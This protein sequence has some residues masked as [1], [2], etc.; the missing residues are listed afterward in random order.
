MRRGSGRRSGCE[1]RSDDDPQSTKAARNNVNKIIE[2]SRSEAERRVA[3]RP[4]TDH[5][6]G[7]VDGL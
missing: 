4:V 6:V 2:L 3:L 1:H 5:A 7:G